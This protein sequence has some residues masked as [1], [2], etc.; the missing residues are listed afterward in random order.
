MH[1]PGTSSGFVLV[2]AAVALL[3]P[4]L[5]PFAL[6]LFGAVAGSFLAMSKAGTMTRWQGVLYVLVGVA[7]SLALS[8]VCI[9]L[10]EKHTSIPGH[11]ALVPVAFVIAAGRDHLWELLRRIWGAVGDFIEGFLRRKGGGQ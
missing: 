9:W 10:L 8:G 1:E 11:L 4:I 6:L 7:L 3:G 2:S 5:G